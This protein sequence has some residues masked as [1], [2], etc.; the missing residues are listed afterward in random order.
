M[1][2]TALPIFL[3]RPTGAQ[4]ALIDC[5]EETV[6]TMLTALTPGRAIADCAARHRR[7]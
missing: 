2:D 1:A 5:W 4:A 3:G 6:Q 7:V